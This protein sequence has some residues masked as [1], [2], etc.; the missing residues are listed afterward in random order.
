[1]TTH[2]IHGSFFRMLVM[3]DTHFI[4][5]FHQFFVFS[6]AQALFL[7]RRQCLSTFFR[8]VSCY[9]FWV[10]FRTCASYFC[11]IAYR[12]FLYKEPVLNLTE[13]TFDYIGYKT[14]V[15]R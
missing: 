11:T 10:F 4:L 15:E 1:M 6:V 12:S 2:V 5:S 8:A 7:R 3:C 14:L 9:G 13:S